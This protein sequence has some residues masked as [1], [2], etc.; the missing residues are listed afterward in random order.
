MYTNNTTKIY[1]NNDVYISRDFEKQKQ[2][3]Y[4]SKQ[5]YTNNS[6]KININND[7]YIYKD[8][9]KHKKMVNK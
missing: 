7:F 9:E 1:V 8:F 2:K 5:I 6:T 3:W 4:T